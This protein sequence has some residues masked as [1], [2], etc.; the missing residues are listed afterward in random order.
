MTKY[1][2]NTIFAQK[3]SDIFNI[4]VKLSHH[5][6]FIGEALKMS[7]TTSNNGVFFWKYKGVVLLR[8]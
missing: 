7:A 3:N 2:A 5:N 8:H 6:K 1:V 4:P